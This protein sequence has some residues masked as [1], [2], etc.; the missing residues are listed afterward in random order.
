MRYQAASG[1]I[2]RLPL[3]FSGRGTYEVPYAVAADPDGVRFH[4]LADDSGQVYTYVPGERSIA[5]QLHGA[6]VAEGGSLPATH[7]TMTAA[8]DGNMYYTATYGRGSS[9]ALLRLVTKTGTLEVVGPVGPL[10]PPPPTWRRRADRIL[11]E[12]STATSDGTLYVML[13]YPLRVLVF[14]RLA[15]PRP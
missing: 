5:V 10:P 9:L 11:V 6:V 1:R 15:A 13:V 12:G 14:P 7:Y 2:E 8:P 3:Q 4:G